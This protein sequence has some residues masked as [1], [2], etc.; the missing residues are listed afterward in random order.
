MT[1]SRL[2]KISVGA[3][4]LVALLAVLPI[5]GSVRVTAPM[6]S[7]PILITRN[8]QEVPS[9]EIRSVQYLFDVHP[10]QSPQD[11][12]PNHLRDASTLDRY[13]LIGAPFS[14]RRKGLIFTTTEV[15]PEIRSVFLRIAFSDGSTASLSFPVLSDRRESVPMFIDLGDARH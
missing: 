14:I 4:C 2:I 3:L 13:Y 7:I 1:R 10:P 5:P 9:S 11:V 15:E 8:G 6:L 12:S